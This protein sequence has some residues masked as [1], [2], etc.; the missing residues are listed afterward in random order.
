MDKIA[1]KTREKFFFKGATKGFIEIKIKLA[2]LIFEERKW[3]LVLQDTC[4]DFF[5][6]EKLR[7][8]TDDNPI[9]DTVT[10]RKDLDYEI[11]P[12]RTFTFEEIDELA[13]I[14]EVDKNN[15]YNDMDYIKEVFRK[16][17]L[18][19]TKEE[20]KKGILEEGKGMYNTS[21]TDWEEMV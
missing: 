6:T 7:E 13:K 20:C 12:N 2:Q 19:I 17:L 11:R 21:H 15:F 9:F 16:G 1:I 3:E 10:Y 8:G 14:T 18:H 5:E 4:Y